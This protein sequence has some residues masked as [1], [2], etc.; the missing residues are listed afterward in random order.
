MHEFCEFVG[1][2]FE[3]WSWLFF[4]WRTVELWTLSLGHFLCPKICLCGSSVLLKLTNRDYWN[5][6]PGHFPYSISLFS[7]DGWY[8]L[9]NY[10]RSK[11]FFWDKKIPQ[12]IPPKMWTFLLH[13][14]L[15]YEFRMHSTKLL[16]KDIFGSFNSRTRQ[17]SKTRTFTPFVRTQKSINFRSSGIISM[18]SRT[19]RK[20]LG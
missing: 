16:K 9:T 19:L 13:Q 6:S 14:W 11:L 8:T 4:K 10:K 18:K 12:N 5:L 7:Y 17:N 3:I 1:S 15:C 2:L 20:F